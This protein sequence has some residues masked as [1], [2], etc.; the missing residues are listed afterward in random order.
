MA[1]KAASP[2]IRI[3]QHEGNRVA[4]LVYFEPGTSL[5]AAA[6]LLRNVKAIADATHDPATIEYAVNAYNPQWGGPVW[7]IP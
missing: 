6:A 5:E 1:G 7:Y 4:A 3:Q 2:A